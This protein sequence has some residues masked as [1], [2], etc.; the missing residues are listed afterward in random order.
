MMDIAT[1]Q[2][3]GM[4]KTLEN[5]EGVLAIN[6][7]NGEWTVLMEFGREAEDSPMAGGA[8]YGVGPSLREA[9]ESIE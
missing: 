2:L 5:Q 7:R 9:L 3:L 6:H 8:L 1:T 4:L